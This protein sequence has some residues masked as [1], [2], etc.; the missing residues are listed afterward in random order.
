[1]EAIPENGF[2]CAGACCC[3]CPP[4]GAP[5]GS[6]SPKV[7]KHIPNKSQQCHQK[8]HGFKS[9]KCFL[10]ILILEFD[11]NKKWK[12][13]L[14]AN[15]FWAGWS[16]RLWCLRLHLLRVCILSWRCWLLILL[17]IL[18]LL[19]LLHWRLLVTHKTNKPAIMIQILI[20]C[21]DVRNCFYVIL[22]K[23]CLSHFLCSCQ[24]RLLHGRRI[25]HHII[26][27]IQFS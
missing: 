23:R 10:K 9:K 5:N 6:T 24:F 27:H 20:L 17:L 13:K 26:L 14:P 25:V 22:S 18:V 1:M 4:N 11:M 15:E 8:I 2:C 21:F 16:W 7:Q 12:Y 3:C 19:H